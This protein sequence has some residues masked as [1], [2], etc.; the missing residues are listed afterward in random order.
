M[1]ARIRRGGFVIVGKTNTPEFGSRSTTQSLAYPTARNPWNL[2]RTP[3]GSSGGAG[4]AVASGLGAVAQGSDG[5]GSIRIPSAWCGLYGI[6]P[7]RGRVSSAPHPQSW[8]AVNGPIARTVA[9]AAALLDVMEGCARGDA[10]CL[11]SPERPFADEATATPRHLR[12]AWTDEH[13]DADREVA[14]AWRAAV[15]SAVDLLSDEG[16]EL[17]EAAPPAFNVAQIALVAAS[18]TAARPGLSGRRHPRHAE[19][20]VG[21]TRRLRRAPRISATPCGRS[22]SRRA[23]S[24]RS[25]TTSTC[26]SR[27]RRP[28][29]RRVLGAKIMGDEDWAGMF[30]LLKIVAF[31]P[32]WNFTGQPAVAIPAG[33]DD[34]GCPSR[35]S[36]SGAPPKR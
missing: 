15:R 34:E 28:R 13:P 20:H 24:S 10:W 1:V 29:H 7:S 33:F 32:T 14:A 4:A 3:G 25:S 12:I 31:T 9:D 35:C 11:P 6:K 19:P 23:T 30:E 26:C 2:E 17:V 18:S 16:H 27:R 8:N 21:P 22:S 5:G 36:S